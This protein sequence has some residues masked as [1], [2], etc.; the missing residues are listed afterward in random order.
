MPPRKATTRKGAADAS[1]K[2]GSRGAK[3]KASEASTAAGGEAVAGTARQIFTP[4]F[5]RKYTRAVVDVPTTPGRVAGRVA[6]SRTPFTAKRAIADYEAERDPIKTF[7]RLKPADP[8]VFAGA[9]PK[10]LLQVVSDKEVEIVRGVLADDAVCERYLFAGVLPSLA[11]QPR[12]FEVCGLPVVADLFAGYNTLLFTYGI[13]NSGKTHTVQGTPASPGLLPRCVKAILDVLDARGLQGDFPIRP[14]YATQVEYCSDPRVVAPTFRIAPGEDAWVAGLDLDDAL[15]SPR[16]AEMVRRLD[17]EGDAGQ[18]AYQLYV[19][20]FEVYNEM[21]YDLLDLGTLTTVHV[22]AAGAD[23]AAATPGRSRGRGRGRRT[24]GGRGRRG[25]LPAADDPD[26]PLSMSAAQIAGLARTALLLRSEGGRGNEAFVEGVTE[27]RVRSVRD[28]VRILIHG[29]MR[30]SVHATGLNAGSSRSHALFQAKL[31]RV[32]RDA[33]IAPMA[34]VPAAA[35][36]SV[37]T[38]TVVDLAGSERAKRTLTHGDRLAEA[39]KINVS[40]MTLKKCL[41]VRRYNASADHPLADPQLVPYNESKVTRLFQPA[42]EGGAKTIMVVCIDPYEHVLPDPAGPRRASAAAAAAAAASAQSLAEAKNVLDF[43]RVAS[44]LVTRVRRVDDPPPVRPSAPASP[45]RAGRG[46]PPAGPL[47]ASDNEEEEDEVFF[48]TQ[49]ARAGAHAR[50]RSGSALRVDVGVQTDESHEAA[51]AAAVTAKRQRKDLGGDW[52]HPSPVP[53]AAAVASP[54]IPARPAAAQPAAAAAGA[55]E[56]PSDAWGALTHSSSFSFEVAAGQGAPLQ[57]TQALAAGGESQ[58][59]VQRLRDAL[60]STQARL[61]AVSSEK[62][63][64]ADALVA[65][66]DALEAAA[67]ELR[68]KYVAAQERVLRI[69]EETRAETSRF[70]LRKIA[71][72]QEAAADRLA[73]ELALSEIKSAHKL[74]ILSRLRTMRGLGESDEDEDGDG[75]NPAEVPTVSPRTALRRAVSR[76]ASKKA[77]KFTSVSAGENREISNLRALVESLEAQ[78]SSQITQLEMI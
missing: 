64:E 35:Q 65:Y 48:D 26:D 9:L 11:R 61:G 8:A 76:A 13:T 47:V 23:D 7:V 63:A 18:W 29:Q 25:G 57:L 28:L 33:G 55:A 52:Q 45:T 3:P 59:E 32:R 38:L 4:L 2:A 5:G 56:P 34:A 42:F 75:A 17:D 43:A 21:V 72:L 14:R 39:G 37:R 77:N 16:V 73:D 30:R 66:A 27:V 6:V 53:A 54:R 50:K 69:E 40:L 49:L 67:G 44:S 58:R 36:A 68:Q 74:D 78:V 12:V 15:A 60:A 51:A 70:F 19:S 31:V 22:K 41:D 62:E 24:A 46:A 10:S 71:Q 1:K 20:Y